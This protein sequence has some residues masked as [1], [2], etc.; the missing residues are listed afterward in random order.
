MTALLEHSLDMAARL[1]TA[2]P[3]YSEIM[4]F[5][6]NWADVDNFLYPDNTPYE[7]SIINIFSDNFRTSASSPVDASPDSP[8]SSSTT[9]SAY[10]SPCHGSTSVGS[11]GSSSLSSGGSSGPHEMIYDELLD[12]DFILNNSVDGSIYDDANGCQKIKQEPG[13]DGLPDFSSAFLD[14]PEIKFDDINRGN[15]LL[16]MCNTSTSAARPQSLVQPSHQQPLGGTMPP[17]TDFK[18]PKHEFPQVPQ[19]CTSYRASLTVVPTNQLPAQNAHMVFSMHGGHL[20]PPSSPENQ[21]L[22]MHS[23]KMSQLPMYPMNHS[24]QQIV[25]RPAHHQ[26]PS[27]L[28]P[29]P[30]SHQLMTPPPS[31]QLLVSQQ[32]IDNT[33]QTKKRGRRTWGRKRQTSHSCSHPGCSKTYT[34]SSHLKAHLRTHTGEKPYHCTWKG[35]GWKF[36]RSDE[37]TRHY[38]KH[39]GD[40]PFQCHLC[41]RAFSRSDHLSLH[42]KR[43]I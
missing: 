18:V 23:L 25:M 28:S 8:S 6:T 12:L 27:H 16:A 36:A 38:R 5:Q 37:L 30:G 42:M 17:M 2:L 40:R 43:H 21:D 35:C 15:M 20:S 33:V 39:T 34:K 19:S 7:T 31:P 14:I 1:N 29:A 24:H 9:T 32:A 22:N 11:P 10:S 13:C 26:H 3:K 41:E 4:D